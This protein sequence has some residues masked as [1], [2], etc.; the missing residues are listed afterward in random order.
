VS[1]NFLRDATPDEAVRTALATNFGTGAGLDRKSARLLDILAPLR[2][3][4]AG[5]TLAALY[6]A[7]FFYMYEAG[8]W[9]F[10]SAGRLIFNDFTA[11]WIE[12]RH[13]LYGDASLRDSINY[14]DVPA[15]VAAGARKFN[16]YYL[17]W[18]WPYPPTFSLILAPFV[19]TPYLVAF[20]S[21]LAITLSACVGVVYLIVRRPAAIALALASPFNLHEVTWGQTGFLR[22]S[23]VGAAL[24]ALERR[25]LL[26]GVFMGCLTFKPQF[27][28]L[29]RSQA[30]AS[31]CQRRDHSCRA[32]RHFDSRIRDRPVADIRARWTQQQMKRCSTGFPMRRRSPGASIKRFTASLARSMAA[33]LWRGSPKAAPPPELQ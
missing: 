16:L 22:A 1:E 7:A 8:D 27:G 10:D 17:K 23:L 9:L 11:I 32:G 21:F 30:M 12:V 25:P 31:L 29:A 20:F 15:A 5:Y 6:A 14:A 2:L 33:P 4:L 28:G 18:P 3:Q 13:A 26:A 19:V 24:L